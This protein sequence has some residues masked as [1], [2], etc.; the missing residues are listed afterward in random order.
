MKPE[1]FKEPPPLSSTIQEKIAWAE[2]QF[3]VNNR[4]RFRDQDVIDLVEKLKRAIEASHAEMEKTGVSDLCRVCDE[5]EG[6]SCCGAGLEN[7]YDGWLLLGNLLLDAPL[8]KIRRNP[9]DCF[10]LGGT[11]C[12]LRAR[13]TLCINYACKRITEQISPQRMAALRAREGTEIHLLFLLIER[14]KG[15]LRRKGV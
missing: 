1:A 14:V 8:P 4:R 3:E 11:G 12:L 13:H 6:G 5:D 7:R 2:D 15:I 9:Q 10:F